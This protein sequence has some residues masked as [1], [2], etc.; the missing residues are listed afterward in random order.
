MAQRQLG[1]AVASFEQAAVADPG[2]GEA[3]AALAETLHLEIQL[4]AAV[5]SESHRLRA[6]TAAKRAY[7][8]D[9]D[10]P[11]ANVAMG[12]VSETLADALKYFK[13][14][15][16]L[17]PSYAQVY[18]LVGDQLLDFD[19]EQAIAFYKKS[20]S[21]DPRLKEIRPEMPGVKRLFASPTDLL[22]TPDRTT[23]KPWLGLVRGLRLADRGEEALAEASALASRFPQDC[24][25]KVVL[26]ALRLERHEAAAAHRLADGPLSAASLDAAA[27]D[28]VRCGLHA[29][30]ALQSPGQAAALLDRLS[31]H[32]P[33]LRAF[34]SGAEGQSGSA[35]IDPRTYPWLLIA[36]DPIVAEARQ[37][38]DAAYA[39]ERETARAVLKGLP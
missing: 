26:A 17:D 15:I 12:L 16:E 29:G 20:L 5:D 37:R 32:E 10:L 2:L 22:A 19:P 36:R 31:A 4:A 7:E 3:F 6:A 11:D 8:V 27:P 34:A 24:E 33:M 21:L 13:R 28:A 25:A 35:W 18:Q 1:L 39:R 9:P 23:P 38:L 30:A 14:A